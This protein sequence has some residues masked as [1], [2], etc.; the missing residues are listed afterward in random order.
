MF[1]EDLGSCVS[2]W[3]NPSRMRGYKWGL[4][5]VRK[6]KYKGRMVGAGGTCRQRPASA[7]Q[8]ILKP[9]ITYG[10]GRTK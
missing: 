8:V 9:T 2:A 4:L 5:K 6:G 3:K 7:I 1:L 10:K